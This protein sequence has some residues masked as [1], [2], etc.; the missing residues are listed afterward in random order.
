MKIAIF[1]MGYVGCV[2]AV[3]FSN[4]GHEVVGVDT[5]KNKVELINKGVSPIV[6]EIIPEKLKEVVELRKLKADTD[7]DRAINETDVAFVCVGTPS[8]ENGDLEL[9]YIENVSKDIGES[10]KNKNKYYTVI[11][12]STVLPGT[13]ETIAIPI[14][15]KYSGKKVGKDFG[16]CFCPEFLREGT[17]YKDFYNPPK[18]VIGSNDTKST[19]A[20]KELFEFADAPVIETSYKVAEM[21]KYSDNAFHA[22]KISFA[23]EIGMLSKKFNID[24][25]QVMDIFCQDNKLNISKA[26]L[27]PGFAFGGSCL[28]KDLRALN[29]KAKIEDLELPLLR[30]ILQSNEFQVIDLFKRILKI[31]KTNIGFWGFSFKEGT[32]DLRE[33]PIVALIE[34][35][36]GKGKTIK[37][38]DK[39]VQLSKLCGANKDYLEKHIPHISSLMVETPSE[40]LKTS[41]IIVLAHKSD[42][43]NDNIDKI[44]KG[45]IVIDLVRGVDL[46][47][48]EFNYQ[49][50]SW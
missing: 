35:L 12:R 24:S 31:E 15:E 9:N 5:N 46:I 45:T 28:P 18:T 11:F 21:V 13:T 33:S 2:S 38:Y 29:H 27:K 37:I 40:I 43:F 20:I 48:T 6:E 36:L 22:L 1:G 23:N 49:G 4:E 32:D 25:W 10:I 8:K 47:K 3:C 34:Y 7:A 17:S 50:I 26:Y 16:V 42:E 41:E 19:I 30:S 39:N 44:G 14:L